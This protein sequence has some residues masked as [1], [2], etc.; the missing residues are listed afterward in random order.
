MKH[1]LEKPRPARA[2]TLAGHGFL[3]LA[4]L[5]AVAADSPRS[6]APAVERRVA[7]MGTTV[8]LAVL[9]PRREDAL[10]ASEA[11]LAELSRVESLLTT[12]RPGGPLAR[13]DESPAG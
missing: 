12:W 2:K 9:A 7:L 10:E 3:A 8:D 13:L 1:A 11:V 5:T 4:A 6:S